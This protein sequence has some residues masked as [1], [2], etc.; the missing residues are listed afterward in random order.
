MTLI[1][2]IML[3]QWLAESGFDF[4]AFANL[5]VAAAVLFFILSR[6]E[7]RLRQIETSIDRVTR[8]LMLVVVALPDAKHAEKEQAHALIL[9]ID[10]KGG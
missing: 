8:A 7:P 1:T 9:E 5:G 6:L 2:F 10:K 4:G 3:A